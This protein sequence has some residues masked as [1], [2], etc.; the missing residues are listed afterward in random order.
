[1]IKLKEIQH[2]LDSLAFIKHVKYNMIER[3]KQSSSGVCI[4]PMKH[5]ELPEK[6]HRLYPNG[7]RAVCHDVADFFKAQG[8]DAMAT[9]EN[10][11]SM[12]CT[13][14]MKRF[15]YMPLPPPPQQ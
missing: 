4:I 2:Y 7:A 8:Y 10:T 1:M 14:R 3:V 11:A 6:G 12:D 13:I 9:F 5:Y 15:G